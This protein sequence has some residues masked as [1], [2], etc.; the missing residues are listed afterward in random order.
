MSRDRYVPEKK[1]TLRNEYSVTS[2]FKNSCCNCLFCAEI[3]AVYFGSKKM[4]VFPLK[5]NARV[6]LWRSTGMNHVC[7]ICKQFGSF[8]RDWTSRTED[9]LV[10]PWKRNWSLNSWPWKVKNVWFSIIGMVRSSVSSLNSVWRIPWL[11]LIRCLQF[12]P[13]ST[14]IWKRLGR[15]SR[16]RD[17]DAS[18]TKLWREWWRKHA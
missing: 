6:W 7:W 3:C 2:R 4:L 16:F 5:L 9:Q 8:A 1:G 13:L 18:R 10:Q 17:I 15:K 11:C 14:W 12:I